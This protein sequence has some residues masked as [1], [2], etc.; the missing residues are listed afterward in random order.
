MKTHKQT[1]HMSTKVELNAEDQNVILCEKCDYK[2]KYHIQINKHIERKH[3]ASSKYKCKLCSFSTDFVASVWE[4]T[5]LI[6]SI[7]Q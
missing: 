4:H 2:C 3:N 7:I 1:E 5:N 6:Y